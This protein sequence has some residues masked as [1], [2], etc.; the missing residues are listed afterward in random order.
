MDPISSLSRSDLSVLLRIVGSRKGADFNA[1]K[2]F[3]GAHA[4]HQVTPDQLR[5]SL[6]RL[7]AAS[8]IV[9][10]DNAYFGSEVLQAA[11]LNECRNCRDTIEEFD[12]LTRIIVQIARA[13]GTTP[14]NDDDD[15]NPF[16]SKSRWRDG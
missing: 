9:Q 16:E 7:L 14:G 10:R 5:E 12:I 4:H 13:E 1:L 8:L 15:S 2:E 6:N 11:F 3:V